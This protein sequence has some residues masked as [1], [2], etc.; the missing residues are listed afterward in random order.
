MREPTLGDLPHPFIEIACRYCP[1]KGRYRRARLIQEHG[2]GMALDAFVRMVSE[3]CGYAQVRTGRH[4]CNGPYVLWRCHP[5]G[6]RWQLAWSPWTWMIPLCGAVAP[7][8][9][10]CIGAAPAEVNESAATHAT[11]AAAVSDLMIIAPPTLKSNPP[12]MPATG[13]KFHAE[14]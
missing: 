2:G 14:G 7:G 1:R 4:G 6:P 5:R 8:A 10:L 12:S 9:E 3:D 13:R 11:A